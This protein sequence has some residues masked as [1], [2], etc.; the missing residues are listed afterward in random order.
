MLTA[1]STGLRMIYE[2]HFV[3]ETASIMKGVVNIMAIVKFFMKL[4]LG[5]LGLLFGMKTIFEA[6]EMSGAA[7]VASKLKDEDPE[8]FDRVI[9]EEE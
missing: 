3:D 7:K 6:G 2:C 9:M 1:L 4:G 5:F 8:A